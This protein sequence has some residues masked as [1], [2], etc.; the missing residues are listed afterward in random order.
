MSERATVA[1][2][3]AA[4]KR[5][6]VPE[7]LRRG[8]G[9]HYFYGGD[10]FSWRSSSVYIYDVGALSVEEWLEERRRLSEAL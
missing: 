7:R 6:G 5:A 10:A 1:K 2:V 9:Y 8:R 4:L 3:N